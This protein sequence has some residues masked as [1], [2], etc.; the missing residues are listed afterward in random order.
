[1]TGTWHETAVQQPAARVY[2]SKAACRNLSPA[3]TRCS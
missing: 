3:A 1:M 2:F